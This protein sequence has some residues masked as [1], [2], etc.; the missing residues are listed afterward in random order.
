MS[1]D[2]KVNE[3]VLRQVSFRYLLRTTATVALSSSDTRFYCNL[4]PFSFQ[5]ATL[6][7]VHRKQIIY[8]ILFFIKKRRRVSLFFCRNIFYQ[9]SLFDKMLVFFHYNVLGLTT[10]RN[11]FIKNIKTG[12]FL[13]D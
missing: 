4:I 13:T 2:S 9:D 5:I 8:L 3:N 6:H 10:H 7:Y 11:A 1:G 12:C